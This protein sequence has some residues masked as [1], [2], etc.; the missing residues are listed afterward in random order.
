LRRYI[1]EITNYFEE[2]YP[3]RIKTLQ[4]KDKCISGG[5]IKLFTFG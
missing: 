3:S 5:N 2:G 4:L 1:V